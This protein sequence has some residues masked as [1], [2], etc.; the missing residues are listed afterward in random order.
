MLKR[1]NYFKN[2]HLHIFP[3]FIILILSISLVSCV[4][5]SSFDS[6]TICEAVNNETLNPEKINDTFE[7]T[8]KN[9]YAAV[10][11]S[12]AG[13]NGTYFFNWTNLNTHEQNVTEKYSFSKK[14][15]L[16]SGYV[17]SVYNNKNSEGV[18]EAGKYLVEFYYNDKQ[19][20]K[21]SFEIKKPVMQVLS[22]DLASSINKDYSPADKKDNFSQIDTIYAC[23]KFNYLLKGNLLNT[24]WFDSNDELL[25]ESPYKIINNS[26]SPGYIS[27]DLQNDKGILPYGKYK[28]EIYINGQLA[29]TGDFEVVKSELNLSG[30]AGN[31]KYNNE[32]LGISFLTPDNWKTFKLD[33][34]DGFQI[35]LV[36]P[37]Q[38]MEIGFL[39]MVKEGI[40]GG[41]PESY[42]DII[43]NVTAP[44]LEQKQSEISLSESADRVSD[45]GVSY[46]EIIKGIKDASGTV[47][48]MP[49]CFIEE[50]ENLYVLY[51]IINYTMFSQ[52]SESIF[53]GI[54]N[55]LEF[56]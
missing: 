6:I 17:V 11:Y 54:I 23:I 51:G 1:L 16:K 45:N 39:L 10:S 29:E 26:Y 35:Q 49:F 3:L 13:S 44:F 41:S 36:P 31:Q 30:F 32:E 40:S 53:Y 52:D 4:D 25:L 8:T 56:K 15:D 55:S 38:N 46:Y 43:I 2:S 48:R 21:T 33:T 22:V 7:I 20:L 9:I 27:F 12:N 50:Q 34:K 47:W 28:V 42:E 18:F 24:K 14:K 19:R 37:S 5:T